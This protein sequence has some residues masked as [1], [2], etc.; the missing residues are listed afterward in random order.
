MKWGL[1]T[2]VQCNAECFV[3]NCLHV[4]QSLA[5]DLNDMQTTDFSLDVKCTSLMYKISFLINFFLI[6]RVI[7][8]DY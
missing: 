7:N 4:Y 2:A 3:S 5:T 1:K 6:L 8:Y